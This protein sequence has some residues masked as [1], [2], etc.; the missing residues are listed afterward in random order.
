MPFSTKLLSE[1]IH[2]RA[3]LIC[4]WANILLLGIVLYGS[5]SYARRAGLLKDEA[6]AD[7]NKAVTHR[8]LIAQALY[9][10]GALLCLID[11]YWSIA[12]IVLV[13]LNYAVAPRFRSSRSQADRG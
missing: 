3:A 10:F 12:F 11:T 4:Y 5:W 2:F 1:F 7:V 6:T 8:I 9:A 13:Q